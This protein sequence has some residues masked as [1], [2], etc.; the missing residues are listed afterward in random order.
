MT[1][2]EWLDLQD[3]D[4]HSE[5]VDGEGFWY[6]SASERHQAVKGFLYVLLWLFCERFQLGIVRDAPM[7]MR[8]QNSAREPDIVVIRGEHRDRLAPMRLHG[9]ADLVVELVSTESVR[10]DQI[11]KRRQY[12]EAG[13]P[14]YWILDPRPGHDH[15]E[16][17][18][19][20]AERRYEPIAPASD[21]RIYSRVLPG[22]AIDPAWLWQDPFPSTLD[23]VAGMS[24][25]PS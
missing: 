4:I 6:M 9:P 25:P 8:L 11:I 22:F 15:A 19:L 7:E 2:D 16:F 21:G 24:A 17:F 18:A 1:Y 3:E 20:N 5:W 12:E 14:E 10:R 23:L 13:V